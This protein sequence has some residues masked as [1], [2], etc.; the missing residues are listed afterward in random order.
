MTKRRK[1]MPLGVK[2]K[3]ALYA[4]GIDPDDVEW[5][6][7][8]PLALRRIDEETGEYIPAENDPRYIQPLSKE[9]HKRKTNGTKSTSYGSDKHEISK[10]RRIAKG[11]KTRRGPKI[12]SQGFD[13]TRKRKFNGTVERRT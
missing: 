7:N 9:A 1:Y 5:D 8:P 10:A 13:K 11:G 3:S 2:V 4:L 12:P 6:H